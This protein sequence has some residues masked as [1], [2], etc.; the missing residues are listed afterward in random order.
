MENLEIICVDIKDNAVEFAIDG[1]TYSNDAHDFIAYCHDIVENDIR[2]VSYGDFMRA[3]PFYNDVEHLLEWE[4]DE[5][6]FQAFLNE[7]ADTNKL[8]SYLNSCTLWSCCGNKVDQDV[9]ICPT[10]KEWV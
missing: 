1:R 9:P 2:D 3:E 5:D 4:G 7:L 10:C 6:T 8:E